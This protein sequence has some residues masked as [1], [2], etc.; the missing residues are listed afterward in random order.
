LKLGMHLIWV[1]ILHYD[2][3]KSQT[4]KAMSRNY[5]QIIILVIGDF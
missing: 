1:V 4:A 2:F 5:K 3:M